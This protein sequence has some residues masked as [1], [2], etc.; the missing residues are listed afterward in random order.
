[1]KNLIPRSIL[2]ATVALYLGSVAQAQQPV[3]IA[4]STVGN[5]GNVADTTGYGQVNYTFGIGTYDVTLTQYTAFLNAVA[6]TDTYGLYN[7]NLAT[8]TAIAGIQKS[9][10]S[11]SYT[12]S[13]LGDGQRPVTYVR[14]FDAAR[15]CNWM[16]NGEPTTHVEDASTTETG[17][18]S[19]NGAMSGTSFT[20]NTLASWYIPSENEW[21]KAAYYDQTLN[22]GLGGYWAYATRSNTLPGN[23]WANRT[24][25]NE[26]NFYNN[27]YSVQGTTPVGAFTNSTSYYGAYDLAGD[28]LNWN[29]AVIATS[30]RG[31]RGGS[32]NTTS[33][34]LPATNRN[35]N[36]ATQSYSYVGF[37][38]AST[39]APEPT[40]LMLI[41]IGAGFLTSR[42]R[43]I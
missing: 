3:T 1:M 14:W 22:G 4:L 5:T 42:R 7:S 28:V 27:G 13:V 39:S 19:L 38:V 40:S 15:F 36:F 8:D 12:Y 17:A 20:K 35:Y 23:S 21:Y 32:W 34:D 26:A 16:N 41:V 25:P 2:A 9:G 18:Y 29:D 24:L 6:Q 11:G 43:R 31:L 33:V 37:R 10:S 30:Y